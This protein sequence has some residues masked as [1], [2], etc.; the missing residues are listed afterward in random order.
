MTKTEVVNKWQ[1]KMVANGWVHM[2]LFVPKEI[3]QQVL[4]SKRKIL[5]LWRVKQLD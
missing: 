5:L 4:D 1:A 2:H 3:R